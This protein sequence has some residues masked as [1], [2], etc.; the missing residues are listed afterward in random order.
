MDLHNITIERYA[1]DAKEQFSQTSNRLS[2]IESSFVS[3]MGGKTMGGLF[4][5]LI[6]TFVWVV[7]FMGVAYFFSDYLF[8]PA[9]IATLISLAILVFF[10]IIDNALSFSYYGKISGHKKSVT[11]LKNRVNSV[12][13]AI[14]AN[15]N[16]FMASRSKGWS[17]S[18]KPAPS[19]YAEANNIETTISGIRSL[20]SGFVN[21]VKNVFFYLSVV[22]VTGM[23]SYALFPVAKNLMSSIAELVEGELSEKTLNI[24]CIVAAVIILIATVLIARAIWGGTNCS[25]T[26][27]TLLALLVGPPAFLLFILIAAL[28]VALVVFLVS[29]VLAI[30]AVVIGGA[31]AIGCLCGG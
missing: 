4:F 20:E 22:L 16:A 19:I 25:V 26:S 3:R 28:L 29:L 30:A 8:R 2:E 18:L 5:S 9:L 23:G 17:Y 1:D 14:N 10:M 7:A 13:D 6:F 24:L 27:V 12:R 21:G 15:Q 31:I 11:L